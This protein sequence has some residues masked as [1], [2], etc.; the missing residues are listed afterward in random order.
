MAP[1]EEGGSDAVVHARIK[2]ELCRHIVEYLRRCADH[3]GLK[4]GSE[5]VRHLALCFSAHRGFLG[6]RVLLHLVPF[7]QRQGEARLEE[8]RRPRPPTPP[9]RPQRQGV[10]GG[11]A[12]R[13]A[14]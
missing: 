14:G 6:V 13:N 4:K 2:R 10:G 9:T 3:S 12:S 8:A 5:A 7:Q 11:G 1:R